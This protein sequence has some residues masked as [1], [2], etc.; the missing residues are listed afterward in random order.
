M[1][2]FSV[3]S[4]SAYGPVLVF[5]GS[6]TGRL[7][8]AEEIF[9]KKLSFLVSQP[10]FLCL[11]GEES[12]G[13]EEARKLQQFLIFK[14]FQ[15]NKTAVLIPEAQKLT[16]EAQNALL[17]TLEEPPESSQIVLTAPDPSWLLP[18]VVSRCR[19]VSL[20]LTM[21]KLNEK[22]KKDLN[23]FW[24]LLFSSSIPQRFLLFEEAKIASD[25]QTAITWVD[26]AIIFIRERLLSQ[27][28]VQY[29]AVIN[30][31]NRTKSLLKAN[32]NVRLTLEVLLL[33]LPITNP[34]G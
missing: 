7:Q 10:D 12:I 24:D 17:K 1:R 16:T 14:P 20:P 32:T 23:D 21:E 3:K 6:E 33:D 13:I 5:G 9:G 28:N 30:L 15:E 8:K 29:S 19:L 26:K 34:G 25:R 11:S 2:E 22:E 4:Q 27:K 18:T 31:L